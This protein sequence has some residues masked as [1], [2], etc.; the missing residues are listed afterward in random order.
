MKTINVGMIGHKFMGKAH[1]HALHDL[2]F[3]F[4]TGV[5]PVMKVLCGVGDDLDETAA[6][7]GWQSAS[8]DWKKVVEDPDIGLIDIAVPESMHMEVA[9]AAAANGKHIFCEKPMALTYSQT[10]MMYEAAKSAGIKHMVDFNYRTL[11]AMRLAKQLISEGKIGRVT[12][13]KAQY[14]QDWALSPQTPFLWRMDEKMAGRG[15]TEAGC[16]IVDLARYL[17]GEVDTVAAAYNIV[18]KERADASTGA[19]KKVTSEDNTMF[20]VRF[21]SEALGFFETSRVTAG[22]KNA[23]L[24][25][26]NGLKGSIRFNLERLDELEL[27]LEEDPAYIQGFRTIIA[28][29]PEHMYIKNWWP[30]GHIIG[31][32]HTFVHQY[33][34]LMQALATDK[35]PEPN[36]YDGMKCQQ[37]VEAVWLAGN[38]NRWVK[39]DDVN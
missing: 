36:F 31:W 23:L 4:D 27:Y 16:H 33:Y 19:M 24:L 17:V 30:T 39:V 26:I 7:Y 38:E 29:Q 15:P 32:E 10:A 11:P 2:N 28:T 18:H 22:R 9:M 21:K 8:Q 37:V 34:E 13:F 35:M 12:G 3:F 6:R 14:M 1:S 20:I 5:R 25:E